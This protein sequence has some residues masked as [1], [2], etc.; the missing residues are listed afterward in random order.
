MIICL[1]CA[2]STKKQLDRLLRDGTYEDYSEAVAVAVENLTAMHREMG[3]RAAMVLTAHRRNTSAAASLSGE[4]SAQNDHEAAQ[5]QGGG[6]DGLSVG[7]C[8]PAIFALQDYPRTSATLLPLPDD[9]FATGDS[10][11]M[12]RWLFG[13][14]NKLLPAKASC[15]ALAN[16]TLSSPE[17]LP[18]EQTA[19]RIAQEAAQLGALLIE[20]DRK[21]GLERLEATATGFPRTS[22]N[23]EKSI[24]R[25]ASQFVGAASKAGQISGLLVGLKLMNRVDPDGKTVGLTEPGL[26]LAALP[27]P[28]LDEKQ[29]S[30]SQKFNTEEI[31]FLL[32]HIATNVPVE[33][34]AYRAAISAV[35][36][37]ARTPSLL[38]ELL[39]QDVP[40]H[41]AE[42]VSQSYLSSQR[43]GA[44]SRMSDLGLMVRQRDGTSITYIVTDLG[45]KYVE[46]SQ[47]TSR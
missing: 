45:Q 3:A 18:L 13:Q 21:N 9:M 38:N 43:S 34:A 39:H 33:D 26:H 23:G 31:N 32:E 2:S 17:G 29:E 35:L 47:S 40:K 28:V 15:R 36:S 41:V 24:L 37:G 44:I 4:Q 5:A 10:V 12:D 14:Y 22:G 16:L 1:N 25:Y 20:H 8:V 27:S 6:P 46:G 7:I 11:T 42:N 19:Y 30:P